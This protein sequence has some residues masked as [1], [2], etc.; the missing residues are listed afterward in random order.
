[1]SEIKDILIQ[2]RYA[3]LKIE[4]IEKVFQQ[5]SIVSE[6]HRVDIDTAIKA[7]NNAKVLMQEGGGAKPQK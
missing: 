6:E 1:M 5:D 7:L 2:L 3:R 4:F